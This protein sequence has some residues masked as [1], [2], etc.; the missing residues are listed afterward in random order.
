MGAVRNL[1]GEPIEGATVYA[2]DTSPMTGGDSSVTRPPA[3]GMAPFHCQTC[4]L[5][6]IDFMPTNCQKGIRTLS[7]HFS[8]TTTRTLRRLFPLPPV[9]PSP[10]I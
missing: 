8:L 4:R 1:Q 6:N 2:Y 3:N 10:S 5:L 7:S 9:V